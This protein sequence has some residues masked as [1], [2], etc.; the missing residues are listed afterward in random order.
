MPKA[1]DLTGRVFGHLTVVGIGKPYV[2]DKGKKMK[3]WHCQCDC[4]KTTEVST[5]SLVSGDTTS[6]GHASHPKVKKI[7]TELNG[8]VFGHLTVVKDDG[9]RDKWRAVLWLCQC[10]CG[11]KT[12][13]RGTALID[14]SI[15]SCGHPGTQRL[16][17]YNAKLSAKTPG[18]R[19][20]EYGTKHNKNNALGER[21]I[22][23]SKR[24]AYTYYRV[25]VMYKRKQYG[26]LHTSL[27]D[28]IQERD[29][30]RRKLWPGFADKQDHN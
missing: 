13:V 12:R 9:T 3:R 16:L 23:I 30:L 25:A 22:S 15:T 2:S 28:A 8:R 24:G 20:V 19:P 17:K 29:E 4:G 27:E 5:H 11:R 10:D 1:I 26:H 7:H 21:N 14:G 18:T 6:C